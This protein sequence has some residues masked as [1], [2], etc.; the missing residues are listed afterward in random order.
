MLNRFST[1]L[2]KLCPNIDSFAVALS[3][4]S[5]S[6]ALVH[7]LKETYPEAKM[8]ALTVDHQLREESSAEAQKVNQWMH[9]ANI[10]HHILTWH[11]DEVA[12]NLQAKARNARYQLMT[13]WCKANQIPALLI[14]HTQDDQAE[15][16]A[17][18]QARN[19]G[20]VGLS[21]MSAKRTVNDVALVRPLLTHTRQELQEWLTH[22]NLEW[23]SDPSNQNTDFT[24]VKIRQQLEK[25]PA[26]KAKLLELGRQMSI[27]RLEIERLHRIF[28][29]EHIEQANQ[30]LSCPLSS[31]LSLDEAQAA[32]TLGRII[33]HVGGNDYPPRYAKRLH[34]LD[35]LKKAEEL[36]FTLGHCQMQR[37]KEQ[38]IFTAEKDSSRFGLKPLVTEPFTPIFFLDLSLMQ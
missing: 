38:L 19:S 32:Y 28:V 24:R 14:G 34:C 12:G 3:G 20:P 9:Q 6:L 25:D 7:L 2:E 16:I 5:D 26:Q 17:F 1:A 15:T 27:Q 31:L 8:V 30:S 10:S 37:V 13:D 18:M 29:S 23:M 11:H 33:Q 4:G 22:K 21:G 36:K 35:K